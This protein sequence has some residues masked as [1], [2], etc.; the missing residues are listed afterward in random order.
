MQSRSNWTT[1]SLAW[2][3]GMLASTLVLAVCITVLNFASRAIMGLGGFVAVGGPYEIASPA[4]AWV[5]LVP[6]SIMLGF[7]SGGLSIFFAS[8]AGGFSLVT[9]AWCA[10]F[11]SLGWQFLVMGLNPPGGAGLA[12]GWLLC[13]LVFIPMGLL[14]L[15]GLLQGSE[16]F[17]L[18]RAAWI[19]PDPRPY[20]NPH[21]RAAFLA[22]VL[23][24]ALL[25]VA[26]GLVLFRAVAG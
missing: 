15:P 17:G 12:W 22:C 1:N 7:L 25:G 21:Y 3:A 20:D 4:P 13:A 8:R 9:P 2:L 18:G 14:P 16:M 6:G 19:D 23:V 10:L 26:A 11:L 5:L 24:G